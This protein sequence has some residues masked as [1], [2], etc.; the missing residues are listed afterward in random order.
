MNFPCPAMWLWCDEVVVYD[1][2]SCISEGE[3]GGGGKRWKRVR[4]KRKPDVSHL[5]SMI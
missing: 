5:P 2:G 3:G 1:Q 4:E